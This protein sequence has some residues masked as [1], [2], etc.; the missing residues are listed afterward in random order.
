M[1]ERHEINTKYE[2]MKLCASIPGSLQVG[3]LI[4]SHAEGGE[5]GFHPFKGV[6]GRNPYPV[7]SQVYRNQH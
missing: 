2:T 5:K 6:C 1:P 7:Y 3:H 4:L